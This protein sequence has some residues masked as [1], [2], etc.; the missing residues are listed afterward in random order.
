MPV[1]LHVSAEDF[2]GQDVQRG[3]ERCRAVALVV[4]GVNSRVRCNTVAGFDIRLS[5]NKKTML[6][7]QYILISPETKGIKSPVCEPTG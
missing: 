3:E 6:P 1:A 5:P 2:T 4:V 7:C